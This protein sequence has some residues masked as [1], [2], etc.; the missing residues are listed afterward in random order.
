[1]RSGELAK[2]TGVS[3]DTLRHYERLG[4][5]ARPRRTTAGYRM[6]P[7]E[8]L[9]R[10]QLVRRAMSVGFTL[11]E[12]VRILGVRDRGGAP[13]KQVH[14]LAASKLVQIDERMQELLLVRKHLEELIAIWEDRLDR[15]PEGQP[16]GLLEMLSSSTPPLSRKGLKQ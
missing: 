14:A 12:L 16:A 8:A 6:Y 1:M 9:K 13:C 15:T 5:L 4:L 2:L 3:A 10:V 11:A 7:A